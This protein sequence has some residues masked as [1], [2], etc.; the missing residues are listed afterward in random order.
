MKFIIEEEKR[1]EKV[2]R[3]IATAITTKGMRFEISV[4]PDEH[5]DLLEI[6][7]ACNAHDQLV[8]ALKGSI[9]LMKCAVGTYLAETN[10]A[11]RVGDDPRPK[12]EAAE[13][14]LVA[15]GAA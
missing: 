5:S 11:F 9:G 4:D 7:T 6:V 14:A 13:A 8:T 1:G 12:L 2:T 3:V 15:A 10:P